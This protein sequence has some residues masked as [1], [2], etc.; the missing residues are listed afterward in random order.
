V[1]AQEGAA[2]GDFEVWLG[3]LFAPEA[4]VTA[5]RQAVAHR[6]RWSLETLHLRVDIERVND[7]E[8]FVVDGLVLQG[9]AWAGERLVLNEGENVRLT[10]SQLRWVQADPVSGAGKDGVPVVTL[11]VYLNDDRSDVMFTVEL[12]FAGEAGQGAMVAMRAVCLTAAG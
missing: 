4:Y 2:L 7:P 10:A 3:G 11:P 6:K 12:P 1:A 5:T 8:A 9:A